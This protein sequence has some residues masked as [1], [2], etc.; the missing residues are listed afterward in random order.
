[1]T[2]RFEDALTIG[3]H[4]IDP[5]G[6][7]DRRAMFYSSVGLLAVTVLLGAVFGLVGANLNGAL[8]LGLNLVL[9]WVFIA[10]SIKRLH[11][12][13]RS[14]WWI[15]GAFAFWMIASVVVVMALS[16]AVGPSRFSAALAS[17]PMLYGA[18]VVALSA[19][20]FGGLLWVQAA[21]GDAKTNRFGRV[22]G[23]FGFASGLP[24]SSA[25]TLDGAAATA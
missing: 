19:A 18:L 13:G 16:L 7:C 1:M 2:I 23:A 22:P 6:R 9:T 25:A 17:S 24:K 12:L 15:V 3:R 11:D 8:F 4:L 14:G 20:P 21:A 10:I 5:R